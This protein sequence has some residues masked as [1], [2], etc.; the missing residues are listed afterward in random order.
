MSAFHWDQQ[1]RKH[2]AVHGVA[3]EEAEQVL[4]NEPIA[5]DVELRNEE[6]RQMYLGETT[7]G[8]ILIVITCEIDESIRVVTAWPAKER[9][10]AF[11]RTQQKGRS[12]G[13]KI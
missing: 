4:R 5:M 10:R 8:R 7:A 9:L 3:P 12:H 6:W 13:R 11:W 1:N 2:I